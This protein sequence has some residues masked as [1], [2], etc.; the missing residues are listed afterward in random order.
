[1]ED[2]DFGLDYHLGKE[3]VEIGASNRKSLLMS[4]LVMQEL[5][6]LVRVRDKSLVCEEFS[7]E[8]KLGMLKLSGGIFDRI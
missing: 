8:D 1:M 2:F 3:N 7:F 6:L 5:D 4:V